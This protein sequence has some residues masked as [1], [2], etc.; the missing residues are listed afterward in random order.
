MLKKCLIKQIFNWRTLNHKQK[1]LYAL[2]WQLLVQKCLFS[3]DQIEIIKYLIIDSSYRNFHEHES[4]LFSISFLWTIKDDY[5][6]PLTRISTILKQAKIYQLLHV[7]GGGGRGPHRRFDAQNFVHSTLD[8]CKIL[9]MTPAP[10][11]N[12]VFDACKKKD[13]IRSITNHPLFYDLDSVI[14]VFSK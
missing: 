2:I 3:K 8:A 14:F 4:C 6:F 1:S 12:L 13:K 7:N 9:P 5:S 10:L 11:N